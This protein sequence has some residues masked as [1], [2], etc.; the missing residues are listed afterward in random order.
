MQESATLGIQGLGNPVMI[1][2]LIVVNGLVVPLL[3]AISFGAPAAAYRR[4]VNSGAAVENL[5]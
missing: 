4:L 2:Y 5:F 1:A 3:M